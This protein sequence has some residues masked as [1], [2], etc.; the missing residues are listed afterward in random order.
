MSGI[1]NSGL[2]YG[3]GQFRFYNGFDKWMEPFPDE[4]RETYPEMFRLPKGVYETKLTPPLGIAFIE[5]EGGGVMVEYLVEGGAAERQGIIAPEDRLIAVT[6]VKVIG[7]KW[8]RRLIPCVKWT[9]EMVVGAIGSN[10]KR[11]GCDNVILQFARPNDGADDAEIASYLE[12]FEPPSD[13]PW[14]S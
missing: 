2:E 10:E 6:A 7:A 11:W 8:E 3:K 14:R 5:R 9:F 12:F 4:D 1:W 13:S